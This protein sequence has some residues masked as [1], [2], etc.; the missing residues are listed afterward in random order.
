M[1]CGRLRNVTGFTLTELMVA[2]SIGMGVLAAVT[3]TFMA[4][5][6]YYNAQEQINAM[7]QNARAALDVI[8]RELKMAGYRPNGGT[9]DG[10]TYST[11]QLMIQ[12]DLDS[13]GAISNSS[14]ANEQIT[15]AYDGTNNQITRKKGT[16]TAEVLADNISAFTFSYYDGSGA[17]TTTSA[18][19]RQ[20]KVDITAKTAKP[21]PNYT[22]NNG[23]RTYQITA[24]I[25]P[26]N[27][28]L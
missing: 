2:M 23:Y 22:A 18:N 28:G 10:V 7:Q 6:R 13:N 11:S 8:T 24:T 3:T 4:Q 1:Q 16:G 25:T 19:I 27:L 12:A 26:L 15:Y 5:A 21:D 14:T 9:F 17:L 20:V